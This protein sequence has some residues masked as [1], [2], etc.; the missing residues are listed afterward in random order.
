MFNIIIYLFQ[1]SVAKVMCMTVYPIRV[2][3]V[4]PAWRTLTDTQVLH[5]TVHSP[6]QG[7]CVSTTGLTVNLIPANM[8]ETAHTTTST[9]SGDLPRIRQ[10]HF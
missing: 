6:T 7:I 2:R 8:V 10:S 9:V 3:M 5:A 4:E 1:G